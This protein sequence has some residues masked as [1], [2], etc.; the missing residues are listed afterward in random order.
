MGVLGGA[1]LRRAG[2]AGSLRAPVL[3]GEDGPLAAR[4]QAPLETIEKFLTTRMLLIRGSRKLDRSA[5]C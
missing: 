2:V 4:P 5:Y 3:G 1:V